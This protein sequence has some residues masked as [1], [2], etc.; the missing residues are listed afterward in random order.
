LRE[1]E[2]FEKERR[3][4]LNKIMRKDKKKSLILL[5][6]RGTNRLKRVKC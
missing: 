6:S 5:C 3:R 2:D 1:L 4:R